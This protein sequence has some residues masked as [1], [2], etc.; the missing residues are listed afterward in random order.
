MMKSPKKQK[1]IQKELI[2]KMFSIYQENKDLVLMGGYNQGQNE[3]IDKALD[4][5]P[6][7][8]DLIKQDYRVKTNFN[9]CLSILKNFTYR[10]TSLST[11]FL[12][13]L[14]HSLDWITIQD[15]R[16]GQFASGHQPCSSANIRFD[17]SG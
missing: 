1:S 13:A 4:L 16:L 11:S 14:F 5:W 12:R 7:I 9:E 3:Q 2:K 15:Q 10:I 8:C 6:K 17:T